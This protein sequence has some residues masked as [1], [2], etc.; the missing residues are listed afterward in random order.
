MKL[1]HEPLNAH[2]DIFVVVCE[3]DHAVAIDARR[4]HIDVGAWVALRGVS[5]MVRR[6][7]SVW[8][9]GAA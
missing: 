8:P 1:V 3:A 4:M 7:M 6:T 9:M 2:H 5:V